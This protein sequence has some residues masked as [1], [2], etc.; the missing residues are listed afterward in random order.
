MSVSLKYTKLLFVLVCL[1]LAFI[2]AGL[3]QSTAANNASLFNVTSLDS[4][5]TNMV[6][7]GSRVVELDA[8]E[9]IIVNKTSSRK[10]VVVLT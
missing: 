7:C 10:S 6:W 4:S 3:G 9:A 1:L 5:L 2:P 8:E